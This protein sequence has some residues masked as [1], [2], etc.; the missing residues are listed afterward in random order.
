MPLTRYLFSRTSIMKA[1]SYS[2]GGPENLSIAEVEMPE[3]G[4]AEVRIKV[5]ATAINRA[6]TLQVAHLSSSKHYIYCVA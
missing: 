1:A 6:D 3:P 4:E 2:P 5:M